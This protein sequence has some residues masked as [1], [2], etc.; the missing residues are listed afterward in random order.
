MTV[1]LIMLKSKLV[2]DACFLSV[3][4]GKWELDGSSSMETQSSLPLHSMEKY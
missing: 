4:E 1:T 2:S 3:E